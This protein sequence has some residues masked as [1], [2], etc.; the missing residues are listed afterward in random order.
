M[1]S[2]ERRCDVVK[3]NREL[4]ISNNPYMDNDNPLRDE[5][6]TAADRLGKWGSKRGNQLMKAIVN[7][8]PQEI[9]EIF[10]ASIA[11]ITEVFGDKIKEG[12]GK[13]NDSFGNVTG[14]LRHKFFGSAYSYKDG[15]GEMVDIKENEKGGIFGVAKEYIGA[16]FN[17]IKETTSKWFQGVSSYFSDTPGEDKKV[18]SKRKK[19]IAASV[20]VV[21]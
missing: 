3:S 10:S 14:Y 19:L 2:C 12:M 20:L 13:I 7:G 6:G 8:S 9:K 18:A 21:R 11:D 5:E 17:N 16:K 15:N 4:G 1:I